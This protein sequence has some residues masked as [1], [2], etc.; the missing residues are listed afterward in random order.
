MVL[1]YILFLIIVFIVFALQFVLVYE[2]EESGLNKVWAYRLFKFFQY[3]FRQDLNNIYDGKTKEQYKAEVTRLVEEI[4]SVAQNGKN[5]TEVFISQEFNEKDTEI[6]EN[7][8]LKS[9]NKRFNNVFST[10]V[11]HSHCKSCD[12]IMVSW[13]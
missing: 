4:V 2:D 3:G 8:L 5:Y 13:R 7:M 1:L 6:I 11:C 10:M 12:Y 9:L